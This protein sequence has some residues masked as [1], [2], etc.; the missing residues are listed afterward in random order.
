MDLRRLRAGEWIAAAS[1][2]ALLASLFLPWYE[3]GAG[4]LG[5][6]ADLTGWEALGAID[7]VVGLVAAA[8]IALLV[9]TAAQRVPAVPVMMD[10]LVTLAGIVAALLVLIRVLDLPDGAAGRGWALW[11]GLTGA[12]GIVLGGSL[13]MRDERLSPPGKHTDASGRPAPPPPEPEPIPAPR[14][15]GVR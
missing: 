13:A 3:A 15:E 6:A 2:A 8:A 1:G 11:L 5:G 4:D 9:V 12:L 14:A 10:A 7:V